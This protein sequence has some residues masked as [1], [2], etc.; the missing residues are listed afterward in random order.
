VQLGNRYSQHSFAQIP[1]VKIGRSQFDRSSTVKSTFDF[2]YLIPIFL[3]E[4]IPGDTYNVTMAS[5]ARLAT[6]VVPVM[7]NMYM[8]YFF[9][10]VPNR[11]T[12][13]YWEK[14]NGA[15]DN[16]ADTTDYI[17]PTLTF[18]AGKPDVDT[19]FDHFGLPTD[20]TADW[21]LSN[22]LPLRCYNRIWN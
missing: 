15:Q 10:F 16:P 2:D 11:L 5:F 4:V 13:A 19:I 3:D 21:I 7:D 1:D 14:M 8:D 18:A 22:T 6:Q 9:F 20:V 17:L 12:Y